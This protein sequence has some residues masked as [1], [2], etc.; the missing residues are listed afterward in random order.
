MEP[1]Q[2]GSQK[3]GK[4]GGKVPPLPAGF[5]ESELTMHKR[6]LKTQ[7]CVVQACRHEIAELKGQ[8]SV[9]TQESRELRDGKVA[10][11]QW[12]A[13]QEAIVGSQNSSTRTAQWT[14]M[15]VSLVAIGAAIA[16]VLYKPS[17]A[18]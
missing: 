5:L 12:K 17:L 4:N 16:V 13:A 15:C 6:K 8:I 3:S 14:S 2:G 1:I 9:L 7:E 10:L 18:Q 11:E